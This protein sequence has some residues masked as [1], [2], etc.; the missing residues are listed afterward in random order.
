MS[1]QM[2]REVQDWI[3]RP[4]LRQTPGVVEVNTVGGY[5]R[6]FVVAPEPAKLARCTDL[7]RQ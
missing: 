3:I 2:L 6:Q 7:E 1:S 4:Q 5:T